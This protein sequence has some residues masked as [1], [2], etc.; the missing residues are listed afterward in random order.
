MNAHIL[1]LGGDGVGPEVSQAAKQVLEHIA[2]TFSHTFSFSEALIGGCA[3]DATG[4]ALPQESIDAA[5]G[6]D[7]ILLGAVG[8]PK[9]DNTKATTRPEDGLLAIRKALGLYAN[10]RPV[11][12]Y[13]ELAY[14]SPLRPELLAN[15]DFLVVRELTGGLYFGQPKERR[16]RVGGGITAVD[17]LEY[18]D[19]E[20]QRILQLAFQ[21]AEGRRK[22]V[23]SV[24]KAN[25][26]E[27]SR[28]WREHATA[29]AKDYPTVTLQHVLVD[30]AAMRLVMSPAQFDVLVTENTFGDILTDEAAVLVGS[31]GLLPSASLGTQTNAHGFPRGLYEPIH[32]SAPDIAGKG[33]ANP[34]GTILS[35][36]MLLRHSLGLMSEA[37]AIENAVQAALQAGAR[38]ADLTKENALSTKEMTEKILAL[39]KI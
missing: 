20:V 34:I 25:V 19:Y 9:W 22:N 35:A 8:G 36:A 21:L 37:S 27:T 18:H 7:A 38:T 26:L 28:L 23:S 33:I 13:P 31:M 11:K 24:D 2:Q 6:A 17:T 12:A 29:M 16:T 39:V 14:A 15:V 10:L 4:S 32:G 5:S 3:I 1:I 30:T